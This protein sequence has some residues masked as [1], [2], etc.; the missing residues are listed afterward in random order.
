MV[1]YVGNLDFQFTDEDLRRIFEGYGEVAT[2]SILR[3]KQTQKGK[4]TGFV[5]MP[6][7]VEAR[8]AIAGINGA[9]HRRRKLIV[10]ES[11][12]GEPPVPAGPQKSNKARASGRR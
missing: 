8:A 9:K 11:I 2:A 12:P 6:S 5:E 7:A 10:H 3:G 1:I 4:G